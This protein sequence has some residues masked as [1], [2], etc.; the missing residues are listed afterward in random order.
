MGIYFHMLGAYL[1]ILSLVKVSIYYNY[2]RL[3]II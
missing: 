2:S 1:S 3:Y